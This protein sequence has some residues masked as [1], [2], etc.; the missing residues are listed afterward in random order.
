MLSTRLVTSCSQWIRSTPWQMFHG[1]NSGEFQWGT[2]ILITQ[3]ISMMLKWSPV[4]VECSG[5]AQCMHTD[6]AMP[7]MIMLALFKSMSSSPSDPMHQTL[8]SSC[9]L[10]LVTATTYA[11]TFWERVIPLWRTR[12]GEF[13]DERMRPLPQK[14]QT[15]LCQKR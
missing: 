4:T 7:T 5:H 15:A 2:L 11:H 1:S 14:N 6:W 12:V 13:G 9:C 3:I 8:L 10:W